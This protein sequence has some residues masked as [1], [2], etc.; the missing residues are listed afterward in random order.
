MKKLF[1]SLT[2][3]FFSI[4]GFSQCSPD[5]SFTSIGIPGVYPPTIQI[6][7]LPLPLGIADG[8]LGSNYSQTL[9]LVVL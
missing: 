6:P 4:T 1:I 5:A 7:N 3:L 9:T 2:L 8:S